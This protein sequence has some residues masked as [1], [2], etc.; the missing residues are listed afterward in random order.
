MKKESTTDFL[1]FNR[2]SM[3]A[4]LTKNQK[5]AFE[6]L[7]KYGGR[8]VTKEKG[9]FKHGREIPAGTKIAIIRPGGITYVGE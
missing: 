6:A 5:I 1:Q 2:S 8:I 3:T 9:I 7:E 4:P